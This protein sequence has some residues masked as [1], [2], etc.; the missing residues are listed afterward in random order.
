MNRHINKNKFTNSKNV[1]VSL[2]K[3]IFINVMEKKACKFRR[4]LFTKL[5]SSAVHS[6]KNI[7]LEQCL[8]TFLTL[9]TI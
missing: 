3:F 6:L 1:N 4:T 8:P 5:R 7:N 9:R 2:I